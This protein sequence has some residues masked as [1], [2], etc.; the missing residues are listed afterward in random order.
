MKST[1]LNRFHRTPSLGNSSGL[2]RRDPEPD[3]GMQKERLRNWTNIQPLLPLVLLRRPLPP[4][5]PLIQTKPVYSLVMARPWNWEK[6]K[7]L[8]YAKFARNRGRAWTIPLAPA[9]KFMASLSMDRK[10][11]EKCLELCRP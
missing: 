10:F 8:A 9:T 1:R 6:R 5:L 4:H 7:R 11:Q 2:G 3:R